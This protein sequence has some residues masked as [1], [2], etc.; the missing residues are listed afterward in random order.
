MLDQIFCKLTDAG[1]PREALGARLRRMD[2]EQF[3]RA[4]EKLWIHGGARIDP[5]DTVRA[6]H[7]G[8]RESYAAQLAHQKAQEEQVFRFA[9]SH[10][11]RMLALVRHFGDEEDGGERC[12]K[13]DSCDAASCAAQAFR[14]PTEA[15]R[16]G[17]LV[18][19]QRLSEAGE[20]AAGA[21]FRNSGLDGTLDRR[22]FELVVS[23]LVRAGLLSARDD[24]FEKDAQRIT[25]QRLSLT[26]RGRAASDE[27]LEEVQLPAPPVSAGGGRKRKKRRREG[28]AKVGATRI[29]RPDSGGK[30]VPHRGSRSGQADSADTGGPAAD[31]RLVETL[32]AWR[33]TEAKK[34][35]VPAFRILTDK[36][37]YGL[38]SMRPRDEEG[39]LEVPGV[40]PGLAGKYGAT[41]LA[42]LR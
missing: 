19:H 21:L 31:S 28:R 6:G 15:K 30:F 18:I 42:L 12:G 7:D 29:A 5:D 35:R 16:K 24:A 22:G 3:E 25:F 39:L 23:G 41:L 40:G 27:E 11:C 10:G 2:S 1:E 36:A 20:L 17:L 32:R 14:D 26:A 8:W 4:L 9:Q 13:C 37:L 38:A 33:L 34:K